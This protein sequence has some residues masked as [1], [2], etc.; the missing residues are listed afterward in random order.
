MLQQRTQ[1]VPLL[2]QEEGVRYTPYLDSL[3]Y[4]T[5]GVGFKLGPQGYHSKITPSHCVTA[6]LM[7]G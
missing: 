6:R 5:V 4:P 7:P 2:R 3:G 1:I